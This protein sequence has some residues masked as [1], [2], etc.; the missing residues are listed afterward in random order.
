MPSDIHTVTD[1][2]ARDDGRAAGGKFTKNVATAWKPGQSGN[3]NGRPKG[4]TTLEAFM[5][6]MTAEALSM[7]EPEVR[8]RFRILNDLYRWF[9]VQVS[10]EGF[11]DFVLTRGDGA[12][13]R[14]E[15]EVCS[16]NFVHHGHD[17]DGCDLIICWRHNWSS[18]PL[19]VLTL[20]VEWANYLQLKQ[21]RPYSI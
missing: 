11:P 13:V 3:P 17:V 15:V 10:Q 19:P 9:E 21:V 6:T 16:Y 7:Q 14:A 8:E 4:K 18:S 12:I 2:H 20:A 5:A 1:A